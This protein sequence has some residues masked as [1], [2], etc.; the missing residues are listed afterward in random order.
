YAHRLVDVDRLELWGTTTALVGFVD[1]EMFDTLSTRV[2][3]AQL[4]AGARLRYPVWR[5]AV[6][7]NVRIDAGVQRAR[8]RL[9]NMA[10]DAAED[11]GFGAI[12]T[13]AVG[14]EVMPL[15]LRRFSLGVRFELGY[16]AATGIELA[17]RADGGDDNTLELHHMAASIGHLDLGG[18]F[19][20]FTFVSTF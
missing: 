19:A 20:S 14:V 13:G 2:V 7:A 15:A 8:V 18:R 3:S 1:G 16:V 9:E 4:A 12:A 11:S 10:G 6:I 5:R 17:P